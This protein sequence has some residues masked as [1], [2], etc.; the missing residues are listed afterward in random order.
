ME[1]LSLAINNIISSLKTGSMPV[2]GDFEKIPVVS[3]ERIFG[4]AGVSE[5]Y[6][7]KD[8]C[9]YKKKYFK[10]KYN[11]RLRI[12]GAPDTPPEEL[13]DAFDTQLLDGL[14]AAGYIIENVKLSAP[15]QD[16]G[17]KRLVLEG[18]A[19]ISGSLEVTYGA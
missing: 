19:E 6:I 2:Y 7:E 17:L 8:N 9:T 1:K 15:I 3:R 10:E 18:I 13:Y 12:L 11:L 4:V 5:I 14:M 16:N